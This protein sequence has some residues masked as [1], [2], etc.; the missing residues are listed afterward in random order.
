MTDRLASPWPG[1]AIL[2]AA[3]VGAGFGMVFD[4]PM[5]AMLTLYGVFA[6]VFL[7]IAGPV[8]ARD[9]LCLDG[10][11]HG[12]CWLAAKVAPRF[13]RRAPPRPRGC[14]RRSGKQIFLEILRKHINER[15]HP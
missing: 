7:F 15:K 8:E 13:H 4:A 12:L 2:L 6:G 9:I 5:S 14:T 3:G 1:R 10:I 11:V